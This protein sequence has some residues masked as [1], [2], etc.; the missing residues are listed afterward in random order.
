MTKDRAVDSEEGAKDSLFPFLC[1]L[2]CQDAQS[3]YHVGVCYEQG[4]GVQQN[5]AEA[6]RHYRQSAAAGNTQA[7]ERLQDWEQELQGTRASRAP[8]LGTAWEPDPGTR[9]PELPQE[10]SHRATAQR[11]Y[12]C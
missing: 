2:L 8:G 11:S 10:G 4:L 3:R 7:R 6:L 12:L 9:G 5:L 1:C